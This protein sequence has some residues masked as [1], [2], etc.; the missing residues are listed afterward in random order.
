VVLPPYAP[1]SSFALPSNVAAQDSRL[2]G[3]RL[4]GLQGVRLG[5]EISAC[6]HVWAHIVVIDL[7]EKVNVRIRQVLYVASFLSVNE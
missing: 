2:A 6:A 1:N 3:A 7:V 5:V 4:K